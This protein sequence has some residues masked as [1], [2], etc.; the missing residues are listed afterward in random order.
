MML[1]FMP[2]EILS[3]FKS[4][5]TFSFFSLCRQ[6]TYNFLLRCYAPWHG[7]LQLF[8]TNLGSIVDSCQI[9]SVQLHRTQERLVVFQ[10]LSSRWHCILNVRFAPNR[11]CCCPAPQFLSDVHNPSCKKVPNFKRW[12]SPLYVDHLASRSRMLPFVALPDRADAHLSR[13]ENNEPKVS[14]PWL[15]KTPVCTSRKCPIA[16]SLER[17]RCFAFHRLV[18]YPERRTLYWDR[19]CT[20]ATN[21]QNTSTSP[22]AKRG[23]YCFVITKCKPLGASAEVGCVWE[24]KREPVPLPSRGKPT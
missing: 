15:L 22:T 4:F 11:R 16:N 14:R 18:A 12:C 13:G 20:A 5:P 24:R 10:R 6:R 7:M 3:C 21:D 9:L 23:D 2:F 1:P 8:A 17:F 19:H